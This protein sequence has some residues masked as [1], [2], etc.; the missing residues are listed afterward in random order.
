MDVA[1]SVKMTTNLTFSKILELSNLAIENDRYVVDSKT[2]DI[3]LNN[4]VKECILSMTK[5]D[6]YYDKF[7]NYG[8]TTGKKDAILRVKKHFGITDC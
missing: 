1:R 8:W 3:L 5:D 6:C 7:G 4:I 2:M